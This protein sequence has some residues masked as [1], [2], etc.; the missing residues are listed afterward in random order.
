MNKVC[1]KQCVVNCLSKLISVL[2][3]NEIRDTLLSDLKV[4]NVT[5][6][7]DEILRLFS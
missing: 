7:S 4:S 2:Y 1:Y 3:L 5:I 6:C